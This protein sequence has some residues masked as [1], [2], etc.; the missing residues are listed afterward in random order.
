MSLARVARDV[1]KICAL[2]VEWVSVV[3][4]PKSLYFCLDD[5]H[6]IGTIW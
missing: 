2:A 5:E 4:R 6:F 1:Y 3:N